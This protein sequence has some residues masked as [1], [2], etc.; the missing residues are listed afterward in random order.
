MTEPECLTPELLLPSQAPPKPCDMCIAT[1]PRKQNTDF[2]SE[3][4]AYRPCCDEWRNQK[5]N[6]NVDSLFGCSGNDQTSRLTLEDARLSHLPVRVLTL[7][8]RI[9]RSDREPGRF[10]ATSQAHYS[11]NTPTRVPA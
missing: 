9:C 4:T 6:P 5:N 11:I 7:L 10:W 1:I 8:F 2:L 3:S